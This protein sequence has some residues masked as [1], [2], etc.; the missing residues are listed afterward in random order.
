MV[1]FPCNIT[2]FC[3]LT[4]TCVNHHPLSVLQ[5]YFLPSRLLKI[6]VV[7]MTAC[8]VF[9]VFIYGG[10]DIYSWPGLHTIDQRLDA[11]T[12]SENQCKV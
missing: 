6:G 4:C 10:S 11:V 5:K 9:L 7:I 3:A 12:G 1:V 2:V 8:T